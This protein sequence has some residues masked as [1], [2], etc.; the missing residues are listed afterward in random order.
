MNPADKAPLD[1]AAG[2]VAYRIDP[3]L[4][5]ADCKFRELKYWEHFAMWWKP[6]NFGDPSP[7]DA[8]TWDQYQY[9]CAGRL[10]ERTAGPPN[11][12]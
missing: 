7:A 2:S 9:Y 3:R 8:Q 1:E 11:A 6:K 10:D 4:Q 12:P 5:T